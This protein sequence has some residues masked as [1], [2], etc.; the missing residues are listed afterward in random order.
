MWTIS[1]AMKILL[2]SKTISKKRDLFLTAISVI[3][4]SMV[5][6]SCVTNPTQP[7]KIIV[8]PNNIGYGSDRVLEIKFTKVLILHRRASD[9]LSLLTDATNNTSEKISYFS[10]GIR[11]EPSSL[12]GLTL[13]ED[14]WVTIN[15]TNTT[16]RQV[17]DEL[18]A[19]TGWRYEESAIGISFT[20]PT[21][22]AKK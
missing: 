13:K 20:A 14:R 2:K 5:L 3:Y 15:Q 10:W 4:L 1:F 16:L 8:A 21:N 22:W 19:Q 17:L 9:V 18:C 7:P 11:T 6:A 12:K